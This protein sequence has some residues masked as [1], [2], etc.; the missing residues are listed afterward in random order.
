MSENSVIVRAMYREDV[1]AVAA[2][3]RLCFP[4]PWGEY[5]FAAELTNTAGY[6]RVAEAEDQVIGYVGAQI[7]LD[8]AHVT[9]FGVEPH[10]RRRRVGERLLADLLREAIRRGC[11]RVTL[12]VRASNEPAIGLYRKYGFSPISRRP[13]YYSDNNEDAIVMWIEDLTRPQYQTLFQERLVALE[14]Y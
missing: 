9:T 5:T 11:R 14:A 2:V 4:A 12:E 3:D 10:L 1:P 7:I 8:E 13:R 6:Y